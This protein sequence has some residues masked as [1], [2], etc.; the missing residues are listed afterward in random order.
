MYLEMERMIAD[1][2]PLSRHLI[3]LT[4][5]QDV[6]GLI[7]TGVCAMDGDVITVYPEEENE[8]NG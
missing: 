2:K 1:A 4:I 5:T 7:Y 3:G 8:P 6:P